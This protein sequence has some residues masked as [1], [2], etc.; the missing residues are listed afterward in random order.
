MNSALSV[1]RKRQPHAALREVRQETRSEE[2]HRRA[3]DLAIASDAEP[4]ECALEVG[5]QRLGEAMGLACHLDH[6][7]H[8]AAVDVGERRVL[9]LLVLP[10]AGAVHAVEEELLVALLR[11]LPGRRADTLEGAPF[12]GE[13]HRVRA[14]H[15]IEDEGL[16]P[17][18]QS[19][20]VRLKASRRLERFRCLRQI[21]QRLVGDLLPDDLAVGRDAEDDVA[22]AAVEQGA[23][24][25]QTAA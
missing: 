5:V 10:A 6:A 21:P 9:R 2:D 7:L 16:A 19:H 18:G 23:R 1:P 11:H 4:V 25:L 24:G 15:E 17:R 14:S 3:E 13:R 20:T 22:A 12:E 8:L